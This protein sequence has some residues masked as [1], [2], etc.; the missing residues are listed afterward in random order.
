MDH[1]VPIRG[2]AVEEAAIAWVLEYERHAGRDPVDRRFVRAFAG[3]IDSPPRIIEVKATSTSYRGWFLPLEPIQVESGLSDP[4][5]YLYVVENIGQG[6]PAKFTLRV[7]AGD[8][9]RHLLARAVERRH[10]E[11]PWP[12]ADYDSTAVEP[13]GDTLGSDI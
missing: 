8:Q 2:R 3:D 9:L 12:T 4:N 13:P 10:F 5:F 7:L 6:D 11:V 1:D